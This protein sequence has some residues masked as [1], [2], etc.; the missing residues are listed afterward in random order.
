MTGYTW[1]LHGWGVWLDANSWWPVGIP[2]GVDDIAEF[3]TTAYGDIGIVLGWD[4]EASVTL[5]RII[6][7]NSPT[8]SYGFSSHGTWGNIHMQASSGSA[9]IYSYKTLPGSESSVI[10][11]DMKLW[12]D[13]DTTIDG[14]GSLEI[15]CGIFGSRALTKTGGGELSLAS[16]NGLFTGVTFINEGIVSIRYG[17]SLGAGATLNGSATLRAYQDLTLAQPFTIDGTDPVLAAAAGKTFTLAPSTFGIVGDENS[18]LHFGRTDD[19]GTVVIQTS[20]AGLSFDG[21]V[22]IDAGTLKAG[23][24]G[25]L[26]AFEDLSFR[27]AAA[28]TFDT[29][30]FAAKIGPLIGAGAI[31]NSGANGLDLSV[32]GNTAASF[33]G[34]INGKADVADAIAFRG[35]SI[36]L[37]GAAFATWT[38]GSD[39]ISINGTAGNDSLIGSLRSD[40][41]MGG[42]GA[43]LMAG[44]AGNDTYYVDDPGDVVDESRP[45]S[46]GTD[47]VYAS[48]SFD[49]ADGAHAKGSIEKLIL[50]GKAAAVI[51]GSSEANIITGNAAANTIAGNVG[52]DALTGNGGDD[53]LE[54][55]AGND[56]LAGGKGMD[57]L[58]GGKN[59]DYFIFDTKPGATNRD[60]ITD[61]NHASDTIRLENSIFEEM[62]R[63]TLKS[64]YFYSG[65]K[66]HDANDHIIYNK[67]T[68][69][70]YHDSDGT[71][72]RAQVQFATIENH[73][74]LASNDFVLM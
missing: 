31:V 29:G 55:G 58:S 59:S 72:H 22:F 48:V 71:G 68:G 38:Y 45:G 34:T 23:V 63:G 13:S 42:A 66:A 65:A 20:T 21:H 11:I 14:A 70:L 40:R 37:S 56:T 35:N 25:A 50:T 64:G 57:A 8:S 32:V 17:Q 49:L 73:V 19:T 54:G 16:F 41:L 27:I 12:F 10:G 46:A 33:T 18:V 24:A 2:N 44:G 51:T 15:D 6:L 30:G 60:T 43:D 36:D 62:G 3:S 7:W 5:G 9:L 4:V 26:A 53:T 1:A 74:S 67:A 39:T 52:N 47:T 69:A 61:F 28:A